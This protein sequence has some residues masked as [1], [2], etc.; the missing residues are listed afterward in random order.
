MA[1]NK[2]SQTELISPNVGPPVARTP[3]ALLRRLF[4][5]WGMY[6][7]L[8]FMLMTRD[9]RLFVAWGLSDLV[10][11]LGSVIGLLLLAERF[12]GI[13]VWTKY[14]VM[15]MLGYASVVGGLMSVFFN[16]NVLF[17]SR[18]VGRGQLDHT[19]IQPQPLWLSLLTEGFSPAFGLLVTLPGVG[20]TWW[21]VAHLP[22]MVSPAWLARFTLN[23]GASGAIMLAFQ[24]LWG[25]LA[26][27][28]PRAAEEINSS[29][30]SLMQEL[31]TFPLDGLSAPL[32]GG[33]MS[34]LPVG[35]MAWF[36]ARALLGISTNPFSVWITPGAALL[37][38]LAATLVFRKGLTYYGRIGSQRYSNFGH[39]S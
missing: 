14:Q 21:A 37:F 3:L 18:R 25:S 38:G 6:A 12:D 27:W 29:T 34:A 24:F 28:S 5:L 1:G 11:E 35:F 31:K 10:I 30:V 33:L 15:F 39:R 26:F 13:G 16:Y 2:A 20:L 17:I 22:P 36:P 32:L 19:L 7:R 23:L 8:D 9:A 4:Q